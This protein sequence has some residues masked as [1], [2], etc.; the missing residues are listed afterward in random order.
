LNQKDAA[1]KMYEALK[2]INPKMAE[3]LK[4]KIDAKQ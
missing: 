3:G 2:K 4:K 1:L